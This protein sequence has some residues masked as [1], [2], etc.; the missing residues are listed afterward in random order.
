M[1]V[2]K[3]SEGRLF[4]ADDDRNWG[5]GIRENSVGGDE[6]PLIKRAVRLPAPSFS[7]VLEGAALSALH[8]CFVSF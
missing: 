2:I 4:L 8:C 7:S 5:L 6:K 3:L 1:A